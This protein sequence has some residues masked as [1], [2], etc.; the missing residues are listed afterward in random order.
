ME[1]LI[2]ITGVAAFALVLVLLGKLFDWIR[3]IRGGD[4]FSGWY[5]GK[6]SNA[7]QDNT[8]NL[9]SGAELDNMDDRGPD[10]QDGGLT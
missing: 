8:R 10:H 6:A 5:A 4:R 7:Y 2:V 9:I 3:G 1:P